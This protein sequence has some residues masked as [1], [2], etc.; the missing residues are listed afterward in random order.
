MSDD[1]FGGTAGQTPKKKAGSVAGQASSLARN[2][3]DQASAA[4]DQATRQIK[5]QVSGATDAAK[6]L[7]SEAGDKLRSV[8][9]E[10]KTAGADFVGG[11]AGAIRR[12]ANEFDREIP[13]AAHYV[14]RAAEQIE[15]V[16][17][18]VRRR[19]L[20]ELVGNVQD[21]ARR[22]PTAFLG[23][24][25]LAGFAAV[26]FL[27]SSTGPRPAVGDDD[28]PSGLRHAPATG[29][30][31]ATG[32]SGMSEFGSSAGRPSSA[33]GVGA[34]STGGGGPVAGGGT[35]LGS[36]AAPGSGGQFSSREPS[37]TRLK[38]SDLPR[39]DQPASN[40]TGEERH[41]GR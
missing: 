33:E 5:D 22:Q 31:G 35:G 39:Q 16:S 23:A 19:D 3:K 10:Q 28:H 27:K 2:F 24:T 32:E 9:E 18:A 6:D 20:T 14:R 11:M 21:F 7:A 1:R 29:A 12:A 13:Q 37:S 17:D 40:R 38:G 25:V 36:S 41:Y 26:R 15:T 4:V 8:V 34:G 30:Y